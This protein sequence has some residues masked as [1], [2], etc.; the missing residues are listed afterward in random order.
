MHLTP[1]PHQAQ[2]ILLRDMGKVRDNGASELRSVQE[3]CKF[4]GC[5]KKRNRVVRRKKA[6]RGPHDAS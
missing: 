2:W 6:P 4:P 1:R 5:G 3:I